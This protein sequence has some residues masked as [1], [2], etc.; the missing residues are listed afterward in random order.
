MCANNDIIPTMGVEIRCVPLHENWMGAIHQAMADIHARTVLLSS[1]NEMVAFHAWPA[2]WHGCVQVLND[3]D[4]DGIGDVHASAAISVDEHTKRYF[5]LKH[6]LRFYQSRYDVQMPLTEAMAIIRFFL[7]VRS[8]NRDISMWNKLDYGM[9]KKYEIYRHL[10]T[11]L[12]QKLQRYPLYDTA[13]Q[14]EHMLQGLRERFDAVEPVVIAVSQPLS[15]MLYDFL[16]DIKVMGQRVII[17]VYGDHVASAGV[18][19]PYYFVKRIVGNND[20]DAAPTIYASHCYGYVCQHS[21]DEVGKVLEC[22]HQHYK[23]TCVMVTSHDRLLLRTIM[24]RMVLEGIEHWNGLG[25]FFWDTLDGQWIMACAQF[26]TSP[27]ASD[28]LYR[29]MECLGCAVEQLWALD[30]HY[31]RTNLFV[32]ERCIDFL[33]RHGSEMAQTCSDLYEYWRRFQTAD[34]VQVFQILQWVVAMR[35]FVNVRAREIWE[36]LC[37]NAPP[38]IWCG[39]GLLMVLKH[40]VQQS[41]LYKRRS[42]MVLVVHPNDVR[43]CPKGTVIYAGMHKKHGDF[44]L[45][46]ET[47]PAHYVGTRCLLTASSAHLNFLGCLS[48]DTLI[49]TWSADD[50]Q[51]RM[52]GDMWM[53]AQQY[54][55][56]VTRQY[57]QNVPL[58]APHVPPEPRFEDHSSCMPHTLSATQINMLLNN[59]YDFYRRYVLGIDPLPIFGGESLRRY[60]GIV[61][62]HVLQSALP[63]MKD[64]MRHGYNVYREAFGPRAT[65]MHWKRLQ[66]VILDLYRAAQRTQGDQVYTEVPGSMTMTLPNSVSLTVTVRADRVDVSDA[67]VVLGDYKTGSQ[68]RLKALCVDY[69]VSWQLIVEGLVVLHQGMSVVPPVPTC[70]LRI[71]HSVGRGS[72]IRAMRIDQG[73]CAQLLNDLRQRLAVFYTG[74]NVVF[75]AQA[76]AG[77]V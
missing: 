49:C 69:P 15:D 7:L 4:H 38:E 54:S 30:R 27:L 11:Y 25:D 3:L 57:R 53:V 31:L 73:N 47:I 46:E 50:A 29:M 18:H 62:H 60:E 44:L 5:L 13:L 65:S 2:S 43:F 1:Y 71:W 67:M 39:G 61:V 14:Q 21:R 6:V 74:K 19:H 55:S 64:L 10:F 66:H 70:H 52:A 68:T 16:D 8:G 23:K 17:M 41:V 63:S 56:C 40:L 77:E 48:H 58:C 37:V 24:Q 51:G 59:A 33:K 76:Q 12:S 36:E 22:V 28:R 45:G 34:N 32:M 42:E 9:G 75:C 20:S 35:P 72:H 26:L